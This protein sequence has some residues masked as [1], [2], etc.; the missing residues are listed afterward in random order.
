[1]TEQEF[2]EIGAACDGLLR[3][4]DT[5]LAR[6]AVPVLHLL[7]EHPS[8][9]R[10]YNAARG[11]A[12]LT[13]IP[14][15]ILGASDALYRSLR[16][17][18]ERN[19]HAIPAAHVDVLIVSYLV[20][21]SQLRTE[22][23][24][25]FGRLQQQL[26]ERG[27]TSRLLLINN[28]PRAHCRNA[29]REQSCTFPRTVLPTS[30][31]APVEAQ[32]W[33]QCVAA[34][35]ALR[36]AARR[37]GTPVERNIATRAALQA[38]LSAS[39]ANLRVHRWISQ[40]CSRTTP[41]IVLT[42]FEGDACERVIWHAARAHKRDTL[43]AGYQHASILAHSYAIRRAIGVPALDCDPDAILT[44]GDI[45][46]EALA[47]SPGL[48]GIQ[49][50]KYGSHRRRERVSFP[51]L[52]E[53]PARCLVLPDADPLEC[54][55]LFKFAL[56]CAR[57]LSALTFA[58]RPHPMSSL[59]MLQSRMPE[60]RHLPANV[61]LSVGTSLEDDCSRARC[62]LYRGSSAVMQAVLAGL[63]PFYLARPG[64]MPFDPLFA[65][66][67]WR[68][69]VSSPTEFAARVPMTCG[70]GEAEGVSQAVNFCDRY[71]RPIRTAAV[72]ELLDLVRQRAAASRR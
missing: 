23:D 2:A 44:L 71:V 16:D 5:N 72:D 39:M 56:A 9:L 70:T 69:T 67:G 41:D 48:A 55:I 58:L 64:E 65:V 24:F 50:I 33:R 1:M 29:Y 49:L 22:T 46:H 52:A 35:R 7:S 42:T 68:E 13:N 59:V 53:R 3:A 27:V 38:W 66:T 8:C 21:P 57:Q 54:E 45:T 10:P 18:R 62:C 40:I 4:P 17:N 43:C 31:A 36:S 11:S 60:L 30:C 61:T 63:K 12:G 51:P 32:I 26:H 15:A 47:A 19:A 28:L 20:A 34:R 25:Y 6:L 14:R 37:A